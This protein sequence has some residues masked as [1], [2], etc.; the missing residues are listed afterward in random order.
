M[1]SDLVLA[2]MWYV[3]TKHYDRNLKLKE[4][5]TKPEVY[6]PSIIFWNTPSLQWYYEPLLPRW[7]LAG[8]PIPDLS[9]F[10]IL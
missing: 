8:S 3:S 1:Q 9:K 5:P 7:T 2:N 6:M 4:E 10:K